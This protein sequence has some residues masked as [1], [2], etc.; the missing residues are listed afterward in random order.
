MWWLQSLLEK[1]REQWE[2]KK[3]HYRTSLKSGT[4]MENSK[5]PYHYW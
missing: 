2:C 4:V 3:C 5:L 1:N